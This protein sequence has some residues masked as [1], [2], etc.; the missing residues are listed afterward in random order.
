[1]S[2]VRAVKTAVEVVVAMTSLLWGAQN[3]LALDPTLEVNQYAHT[4]WRIRDGFFRGR[5]RDITQSADG[6]VWLAS[7]FGV[8]RFDGIRVVP[9]EPSGGYHLPS[10]DIWSVLAGRDGS[11]WIGTAKGLARWKEGTLIEYPDF[12]GHFV[13]TLFEDRG[14]TVWANGNASP[15]GLFCAIRGRDATCYGKDGSFGYSPWG[16]YEDRKGNL[17]VGATGGVWKWRPEP[18][19]F[20]RASKDSESVR[21][22][23]ED[24]EGALLF[25]TESGIRR[26][27]GSTTEPYLTT[28][29]G[30]TV[31]AYRMLQDRDRGLWIGTRNRG[32]VHVSRGRTDQF[33]ASDGLSG[34]FVYRV[35]EDREGNIWIITENGLDRFRDVAVTRVSVKQGLPGGVDS[36]SAADDGGVW[37]TDSNGLAE[38]TDDGLLVYRTRRAQSTRPGTREHVV[39]GLPV[40][41]IANVFED[42]RRRVWLALPNAATPLGYLR[43][44][45]F[46]G[47]TGLSPRQP[48][49]V[50]EDERGNIW[51]SDQGLGLV[52]IS[53]SGQVSRTPWSAFSHT[54]FATAIAPDRVRGGLWL[55][56]FN[57]GVAYVEGGQLRASYGADDGLTDGWVKALAFSSDGALWVAAEGGLSRL[58]DGH[59]ATLTSKNGLPCDAVNWVI[60]DDTRS[61]W[62]DMACGLVRLTH[63]EVVGWESDRTRSLAATVFGP[64]DGVTS[65]S[66]PLGYN[67]YVAKA[68]DG[69]L[70][71][72]GADGANVIDPRHL[73]FNALPPPV[74]VERMIADRHEYNLMLEGDQ[75]IRLPALSRDLQIDY[76]A[77]SLVAS[78][79]NRFKIKLEGWDREWQDMGNRRQ[80]FYSNL[81]PR[82]YR[83]RV[84]ASNNS[85]VWNEAG[86]TLDFSV[87]PAYYQTVWFG[88]TMVAAT[89]ALVVGLYQLRLRQLAWQFNMRLEERVNERTRV[90]RDLHDTLLQ[91]FQGLVLRF[92]AATFQLPQGSD[93]ARR[94]LES[95][96]EDAGRAI[97]EARDA[98]QGLRSATVV[99]SDLPSLISALGQEL[100]AAQNDQGAP[101]LSVN[102]EGRPRDLMPIVRDEIYRIAREALRNAFR[103]A[104]ASR[105]QVELRYA[106]QFLRLRIRDDGKGVDREVIEQGGRSGHYGLAGMRERA[107]L[108]QATLT[109]W[110]ERGSGTEVELMIPSS[111]AYAKNSA[112][113]VSASSTDQIR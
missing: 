81:P 37:I 94:T 86:A 59:V 113:T 3:A 2:R 20:F 50:I 1:M 82:T 99:N 10:N 62:L 42:S 58:Q 47:L 48:R 55:G 53:E 100:T 25:T 93:Q 105:I 54:D 91:S 19:A 61:L 75:P 103:H 32:L 97:V 31:K 89:L 84:I 36:V 8:L 78:E 26:V 23:A 22:F 66:V 102:V 112:P 7:E 27:V 49:T 21:S 43:D 15:T 83:F 46:T 29:L 87:A 109:V 79:A 70:W 40:G 76:T 5:I 73:P 14:G 111:V 80:A 38:W 44:D 69:R 74:H 98:V 41:A 101:G 45:T 104:E 9:W 107:D 51:L 33:S 28:A 4:A 57:G 56:F 63:Q 85:G 95:A 24:A 30:E 67:P 108:V 72:V 60:E 71:F 106:P 16:F 110:S 6:Y 68:T 52:R 35:F 92:Q 64:A 65:H 88:L 39:T 77:L 90:A 34:Q 18:R 11:L 13:Q 17:W 12:S 96:L